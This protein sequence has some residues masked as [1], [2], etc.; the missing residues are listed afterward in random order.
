[1]INRNI[2]IGIITITPIEIQALKSTF[3]LKD[4]FDVQERGNINYLRSNIFSKKSNRELA[5]VFAYPSRKNG[6]I[7]SAITTTQFLNDWYPKLMC[8]VGI[9]AGVHEKI[10]IGDVIIPLQVQDRTSKVFEN[11]KYITDVVISWEMPKIISGLLKENPLNDVEFNRICQAEL[12]SEIQ[13]AQKIVMEKAMATDWSS[14]FKIEDGTLI[15]DNTLVHDSAY[16]VGIEE[17]AGARCCGIDMEA[18]GFIIACLSENKDFPYFISRGISDFGDN[19]TDDFQLLAARTADIALREILINCIDINLI[20]DNPRGQDAE[21]SF[22]IAA[23]IREAAEKERYGEVCNLATSISQVLL[24]SGKYEL[25]VELGK[26]AVDAAMEIEDEVLQAKFYIDDIGWTM[27]LLKNEKANRN[28]RRGLQIAKRISDHYLMAKA[29]RHTASISR[30]EGKF[31][32]ARRELEE[33]L[34]ETAFIENKKKKTE[35]EVSL[36]FSNAKLLF[37]DRNNTKVDL[38]KI[39]DEAYLAA[40]QFRL[41]GDNER[42]TKIYSFLGKVYQEYNQYDKAVDS[43]KTGLEKSYLIGRYDEI[44]NNTDALIKMKNITECERKLILK[45]VIQYCKKQKYLDISYWNS[46][47]ENYILLD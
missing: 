2:D 16:F 6:N 10:H 41:L 19:K 11:G 35:M 34:K 28:I 13:N 32:S 17:Y 8:L 46:L 24:R 5:I 42:E 7:L 30:R 4:E 25:R 1:M 29:H 27:Y 12:S 44:K 26:I 3:H 40:E 37:E 43:Y 14:S 20:K 22:D 23:C 31:T 39:E 33:A 21:K 9:A 38:S 18:A 36:R 47:Y 45:R 15:S